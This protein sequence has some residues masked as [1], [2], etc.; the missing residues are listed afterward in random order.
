MEALS[1]IRLLE[2]SGGLVGPVAADLLALM[3]A[4]VIKVES[5][6]RL[7][8]TRLIRDPIDKTPPKLNEERRY[9]DFNLNK[10]NICVDL[11]KPRGLELIKKLVVHCDVILE[12]FSAGTIDKLGL[13]YETVRNLRPDIIMI[14]ASGSGRGGRDSGTLAVAPIFAALSGLADLTGYPD[15]APFQA[16]GSA[17]A[18][19]AF[20]VAMSIFAALCY[21]QKTG[22]GQYIDYSS[23]EGLSCLVGDAFMDYFMNGRSQ[24]RRANQDDTMAPHNCY[25]CQG[26]DRWVSIVV[27]NEDEWKALVTAMGGPAWARQEKFSDAHSRWRNQEELDQYINQWTK[28]FTPQ[29]VTER[30]QMVGVAAFPS[31]TGQ[32]I[33]SNPHLAER[34]AFDIIDHPLTG[35]N[36]ELSLPWK[37]SATPSPTPRHAPLLGE[38]NNYV[39]GD[40]LGL[41]QIEISHLEAEEV[42][43]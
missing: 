28:D 36:Q 4:E 40:L 42:L 13:G 19:N 15:D 35:A 38:H 1:G 30:L 26:D 39:F 2:F 37:F 12:N 43:W 29:E 24:G 23:R 34:G 3:G 32:D 21:R 14:S 10:L 22:Q 11:T 18:I 33:Y 5:R 8:F 27:G 31:F 16:R 20:T 9:N 41:T 17:D 6:K 25:H 7:D